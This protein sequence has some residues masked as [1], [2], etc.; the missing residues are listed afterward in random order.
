MGR[1]MLIIAAG[2]IIAVG[3]LQLGVQSKRTAIAQNSAVDAYEVEVR[4]KAF[5]AAQLTMER[6]NASGGTWHPTA[7]NPWVQEIDG[8]P[9]SLYYDLMPTSASGNFAMLEGDTVEIHAT[10][11]FLDPI[12][13]QE[14]DID[15]I[16]NYVKTSMHF[17]PEFKGAMQFA[18]DADDF[19]FGLGGSSAVIGDDN[20][21]TCSPKPAVVVRDQDSY[22]KVLDGANSST[23]GKKGGKKGGGG[24]G[25]VSDTAGIGIDP[26]LS[27]K[28]VDQLVARLAQMSD[29]TKVSGNYKG[30]F[31]T[32]ENPGIFFVEDKARLT[33]GIEDGY[34]IMVVRSGGE[35]EYEGELFVAGNFEFNGLVIFENAYDMTG[36]GTPK[37]NGSVLIGK[38][39]EDSPEM[40]NVDL[41]GTIDIQ[42]DCV[43]E[44][45]AQLAS[46]LSLGQ[47]RYK[48]LSTYE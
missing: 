2:A 14:K 24:G 5:T 15:I 34:G 12:T 11:K 1:A 38:A 23:G 21:G 46:A 27:Y 28:P 26:D 44:K 42:Y 18:V 13:D 16:T 35:L 37:I 29:V 8:T 47:N 40:L 22:D 6:I 17:V 20:S 33:G 19:T 4:N 10:A 3:I 48:R 39:D 7:N 36:R 31:G 41:G 9:I 45:Y 30:S 32:K 43:A 25:L